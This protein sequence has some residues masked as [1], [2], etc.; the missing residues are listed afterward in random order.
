MWAEFAWGCLGAAFPEIVRQFDLRNQR[1]G[2]PI[3]YIVRSAVFVAAS[4]LVVIALPDQLPALT[5]IYAGAAAPLI[6]NAGANAYVRQK[7]KG[8]EEP[9]AG[10]AGDVVDDVSTTET[11]A[12]YVDVHGQMVDL[13]GWRR[14]FISL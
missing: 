7:R 10:D 5:A 14:F 9:D 6:V 12:V 4:G 3:S 2:V 13:H 11:E 1:V 8:P